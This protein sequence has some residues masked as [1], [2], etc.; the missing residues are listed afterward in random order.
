MCL[1]FTKNWSFCVIAFYL[2]CIDQMR[3]DASQMPYFQKNPGGGSAPNTRPGAS[4]LD[5]AGAGG[6]A[7]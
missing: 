1:L 5:P 3:S 2:F 4:L 6:C 7:P